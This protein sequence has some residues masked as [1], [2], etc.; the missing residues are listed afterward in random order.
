MSPLTS[1]AVMLVAVA[2]YGALHSWLAALSAKQWA[3][4]VLGAPAGRL[5]R[6]TFN[7]IGIVT[8]LPLLAFV[9]WQPGRPL[10]SLPPPFLWIFLA[11]Q[12]AA[13]AVIALGLL[14]T[15][16]WHFLGL[17]QL[18]EPAGEAPRLTTSGLYRYV[19]HPLYTAGFVFI[20]LTPVMTTT[21]FAFYFG[22]SLYLYVGSVFEERRLL[23]E[24]GEAYRAYQRRVPRLI[25]VVVR[26]H[27]EPE[28]SSRP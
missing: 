26:R 18:F 28:P 17:R 6:V 2:A 25:P 3:R 16:V 13:L 4:R 20:W 9:A 21:L 22:L 19:R 23:A 15:D 27:K 5:Y 12:A 1:A 10:Y 14:Q 7:G 8:L 24:F 11:G